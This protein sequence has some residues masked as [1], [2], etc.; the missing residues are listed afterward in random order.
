MAN[1][2]INSRRAFATASRLHR[3][4]YIATI[5]KAG[6]GAL[7]DKVFESA[8]R[9]NGEIGKLQQT[10][11][12]LQLP[13][14]IYLVLLLSGTDVNLT[15]F[16]ITATKNLRE[17]LLV[18]SAGLGLWSAW[19]SHRSDVLE[20]LLRAK[21]EC[22]AK[23][24]SDRL[25]VLNT[26]AGLEKLTIPR[27]MDPAISASG[28]HMIAAVILVL[29][30]VALLLLLLASVATV[31]YLTLIDIYR[32]PN[33]GP[34]FTFVVIAFVLL[35]DTVSFSWITFQLGIVPYKN[36]TSLFRLGK[37]FDTDPA[38][39]NA[40]VAEMMRQHSTKGF[41]RRHLSRPRLPEKV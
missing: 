33:F 14:F 31:H 8:A 10:L 1:N 29:A 26:A 9:I 34:K 19:L 30:I 32:H 16:G 35:A 25:E 27:Q 7:T 24:G 11:F 3:E 23:G 2:F 12:F 22:D 18:V 13:T 15:V 40:I 21:N 17:A 38:K 5:K 4:R 6:S 28:L 39:A 36:H 37:L 41:L 20:S